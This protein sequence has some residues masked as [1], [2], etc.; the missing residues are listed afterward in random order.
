MKPDAPLIFIA[1][2]GYFLWQDRELY[3]PSGHALKLFNHLLAHRGH[4][5]K[6]PELY[7]VLWPAADSGAIPD[8]ADD[9]ISINARRLASLLI[10]SRTWFGYRL[11]G[12]IEVM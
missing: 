11:T 1:D 4:W 9:I 10:E 12:D 2:E 3:P 7:H 6:K 5:R 8:R